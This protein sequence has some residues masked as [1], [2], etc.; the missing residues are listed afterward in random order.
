MTQSGARKPLRRL[1]E[2]GYFF[3][4]VSEGSFEG[5]AMIGVE[6]GGEVIGDAGARELQLLDVLLAG[7]LFGAFWFAP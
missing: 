2:I 5:L 4:Q 7:L 3:V 1:R 6:S